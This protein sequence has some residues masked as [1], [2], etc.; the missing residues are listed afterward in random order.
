MGGRVIL[1]G[2]LATLFL[3]AT[4][5]AQE[6]YNPYEMQYGSGVTVPLD[7]LLDMPEQYQGQAVKT[8]GRLDL[9]SSAAAGRVFALRGLGRRAI[10]SPYPQVRARFEDEALRMLGLEVEVTGLVGFGTDPDSQLQTVYIA[11]WAWLGPPEEKKGPLPKSADATL[12]DL[13]THPG[14]R[15]G[16]TVR[17]VGQFRGANLYGDLPSASRKRSADWV[18][19]SDLFAAWVTGKK[20]RGDGFRLD[21]KLKRDTGKWI[22]VVGRVHTNRGVVYIEAVDLKLT[23]AP[24]P[25]AKAEDVERPP[26]PP[27]EPPV[28]VFS[29]PLDGEREVP[30]NS[31]FKVQFS[32]DMDEK[33]FPGR[34]VLRYAGRPRPGDRP[35]DAVSMQYDVGH[36]ALTVDPGDLL[37]PGRVVELLLLP[38]ILDINGL[39][40]EARQG[41]D[42]GG[43]AD[44]LRFQI[45]PGFVANPSP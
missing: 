12:E 29:L 28:V 13:V 8:S 34:V 15:D 10:L 7:T 36:R 4:L 26:P 38:G 44:V 3:S 40:L 33:T 32:A 18:L 31:V 39:A 41:G 27:P 14:S 6:G 1:F 42:P 5:P 45:A 35:L 17:V 22:A 24:S 30:P 21:P 16:Q 25:E 9:I 37:R 23:K 11:I 2:A 43:A 20:P 19:K